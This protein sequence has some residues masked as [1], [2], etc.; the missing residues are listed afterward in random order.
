[1]GSALANIAIGVVVFL[2]ILVILHVMVVITVSPIL[3]KK[4]VFAVSVNQDT[5]YEGASLDKDGYFIGLTPE[6]L[7]ANAGLTGVKIATQ[8]QIERFT[9]HGMQTCSWSTFLH[10]GKLR[11]GYPLQNAQPGSCQYIPGDKVPSLF[12]SG[13]IEKAQPWNI[14]VYGVKPTKETLASSLYAGRTV[15]PFYTPAAGADPNPEI[16]SF[17]DLGSVVSVPTTVRYIV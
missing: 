11:A 14:I 5:V 4:E 12:I 6:K 10:D 7:L 1:M 3:M 13:A 9:G 16:W 8:E 17:Y 2:I 15:R